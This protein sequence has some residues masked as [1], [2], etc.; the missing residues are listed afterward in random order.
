MLKIMKNHR[1]GIIAD[2]NIFEFCLFDTDKKQQ[3]KVELPTEDAKILASDRKMECVA[4]IH[5]M[6]EGL[7]NYQHIEL[8][9]FCS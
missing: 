2:N 4:P 1:V 7:F 6:Y 3:S 5:A 8:K 9:N